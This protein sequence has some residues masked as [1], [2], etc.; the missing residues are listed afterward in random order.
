[1]SRV[2]FAAI[3]WKRLWR[4]MLHK[5]LPRS[6]PPEPQ[7][8]TKEQQLRLPNSSLDASTF[9]SMSSAKSFLWSIGVDTANA[10]HLPHTSSLCGARARN[11]ACRSARNFLQRA[12][13]KQACRVSPIHGFTLLVVYWYV[14]FGTHGRVLI[15]VDSGCCK[16]PPCTKVILRAQHPSRDR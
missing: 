16:V 11:R 8:F 13:L 9:V 14:W 5:G 12:I 2:T 4:I 7:T 3:R 15:S 10:S 1:M 6:A